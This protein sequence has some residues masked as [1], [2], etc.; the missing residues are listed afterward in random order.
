[1]TR[2]RADVVAFALSLAWGMVV[3]VIA[4]AV[5]RSIQF[6]IYPDPNPA[7]V[8]WSAHSGYFWRLWTVGYAGGI[9]AF[10]ALVIARRHVEV[11]ARM[12]APALAVAATLLSLQAV[13]FP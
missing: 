6:A 11:C 7:A 1:V 2:E 12:L 9:A 10:S 8:V 4:Y 13:L 5:V 3:A